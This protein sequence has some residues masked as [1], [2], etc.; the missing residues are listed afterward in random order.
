MEFKGSPRVSTVPRGKKRVWRGSP[1]MISYD[2]GG[3]REALLNID[4]PVYVLR[5]QNQIGV[6]NQGEVE[7]LDTVTADSIEVLATA[8]SLPVE[9]LGDPGFRDFYGV[10]YSYY[11]GAMAHGIASEKMIIKLGKAGLMG[12]FGAAGMTPDELEAAIQ[13]I[14]KALP[15]GPYAFN[16]IHSPFEGALERKSVDLYLKYGVTAIEASAFIRMTPDLVHYRVAGLS[17]DTGGQIEI[18][19]RVIAKLSRMEVASQFMAPAPAR[20]LDQLVAEKRITELQTNLAQK[21]PIADDITVEADS[22]GHT[23]NRPLVCLIPAMLSWRDRL[24]AKYQ[25]ECPVRIGAAGGIGTP[26][27]AL[28][29]F[30]MGAAYVVTGSINHACIEASASVHT[31]KLLAQ[32]GMADVTM[33]P[34]ADM[35][36][37]GVKVQVLKRGSLFAMRAQKL[38]DL[39]TQYDSIEEIPADEI[40]NLEQK[41]FKKDINSIWE[42]TTNFFA[43]RN[44]EQLARAES[45]P[46]RKM[47]L[48]FRWY[49]GLSSRWSSIGEKG[50]EMDYQI[51]CGPA[52]GAFN[53]WVAG[54]YLA[55]PERRK[56]V[57]IARHI[58]KGSA[59]LFRLQSLKLKGLRMPSSMDGYK[60]TVEIS[61]GDCGVEPL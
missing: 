16:L 50:R 61:Q 43:E 20:I 28:G 33:A 1:K 17:L 30:M 38:Y 22:G 12:S 14:Q 48:I 32:A 53:D 3:I 37:M 58:L 9:Q 51:W 24:R 49:L 54:T 59:Y 23:D 60:P 13:R 55:D 19:N 4:E 52:I 27:S 39:Y 57:D 34:S 11:A 47:A 8:H 26:A 45:S 42:E 2:E 31:R 18:K 44:P 36:E 46:K 5:Y 21:V 35:F 7:Y 15:D 40:K 10:R 29:A 25:Y 56:V 41:I 6:S